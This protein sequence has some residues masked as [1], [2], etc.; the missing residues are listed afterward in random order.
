M[1]MVGVCMSEGQLD[2]AGVLGDGRLASPGWGA[3]ANSQVLPGQHSSG[4]ETMP[5]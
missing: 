4:M 5:Y 2:L 3:P 1:C